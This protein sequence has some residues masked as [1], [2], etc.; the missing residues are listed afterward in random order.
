M[1]PVRPCGQPSGE[2][3]QT[4]SATVRGEIEQVEG[5]CERLGSSIGRLV[6]QVHVVTVSQVRTHDSAL[7]QRGD[8][9][10]EL[11]RVPGHRPAHEVPVRGDLVPGPFAEHRERHVAFG[12]VAGAAAA[13]SAIV[14]VHPSHCPAVGRPRCHMKA[15]AMSMRRPSNTSS[16]GTGPS[17]PTSVAAR[18][19]GHRLPPPFRGDRV[20]GTSVAFSRTSSSSRRRCHSSAIDDA[21]KGRPLSVAGLSISSCSSSFS[22]STRSDPGVERRRSGLDN[23]SEESRQHRVM[24]RP[25]SASLHYE[26]EQFPSFVA[27]PQQ[28][29]RADVAW[30]HPQKSASAPPTSHLRAKTRFRLPLGDSA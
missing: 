3:S 6:G 14:R 27:L 7:G 15:Y 13:M 24:E 12:E 5:R 23:P 22:V 28:C 16:S 8:V 19:P 25:R 17:A 18:Y 4:S 11:G 26:V 9:L 1:L 21:R 30:I 10:D 2:S 20:S 29:L